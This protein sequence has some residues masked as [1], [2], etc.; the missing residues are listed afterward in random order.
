MIGFFVVVLLILIPATALAQSDPELKVRP[1]QEVWIRTDGGRVI[2][3]AIESVTVDQLTIS[4]AQRST[5]ERREI[6]Q[7]RVR[8]GVREG[9][10]G[11]ALLGAGSAFFLGPLCDDGECTAAPVVI[12]G[13]VGAGIGALLDALTPRKTVY[14]RGR[15]VAVGPILGGR[16]TGV[17]LHITWNDRSRGNAPARAPQPSSLPMRR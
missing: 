4:G 2:H 3:G 10:I 5:I 7:V 15:R 16:R 12:L 14:D 9:A 11:G 13:V 17:S 6:L 1:G 8:D